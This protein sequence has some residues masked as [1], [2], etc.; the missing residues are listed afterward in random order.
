VRKYL[1]FLGWSAAILGIV[2][3]VLR[4]FF[5]KTWVV[6]SDDKILAASIAPT[7]AP[8]DLVLILHSREPAFGDLARCKDP[9]EPRRFVIGRVAGEPGDSVVVDGRTIYVNDRRSTNE[10]SCPERTVTIEEPTSGSPIEIACDIED[11]SGTTHM[12]GQRHGNDSPSKVEKTVPQGKFWLVS[13]N[14]SYPLDSRTYGAVPRESC[15][16]RIVYRIWSAKGFKDDLH[17][18]MFIK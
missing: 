16:A 11:L 17:R 1:R 7:L 9:E 3:G 15:D 12:R 18:F 6:P 4:Y 10:S 8:G 5:F 14:R 13:D 2:L